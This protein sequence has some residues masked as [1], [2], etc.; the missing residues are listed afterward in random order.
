VST[1]RALRKAN[2]DL[3]VWTIRG[4]F[5][6]GVGQF[7]IQA[8]GFL[9]SVVLA[10]LLSPHDYGLVT[11]TSLLTGLLSC[12]GASALTTV[13]VQWTDLTGEDLDTSFWAGLGMGIATA[14]LLVVGAEY[15]A[16]FFREPLIARLLG[17]QAVGLV[18]APLGIVHSA[19]LLRNMDFRSLAMVDLST[20]GLSGVLAI[21]MALTGWGVWSLVVP[22]VLG[23]ALGT[24]VLWRQM[25][26]RARRRM[27]WGSL[28][29]LA[30]ASLSVQTFNV[31]N[32]VRGN[33]DYLVIGRALG[34]Q[35]LGLYYLA[36]TLATIPQTR[37]VPIATRV[38]FPALSA[39][40]EDPRRVQTG[41]TRAV[42]YI[43]LVTFPLLTGLAILAP[44]FALAVFGARW[45]GAAPLVRILC[46][47]GLLYAVG[48]TTG[49][50]LFSQG[51]AD[52]ACWFGA[53]GAALVTGCVL[54]GA[55]S[56]AMGIAI[57]V[58]VYALISFLP[59]QLL[60]NR[61]IDLG[62]GD[63]L[64]S[65]IPAVLGSV[66]MAVGL[67]LGKLA[68]EATGWASPL[69]ALLVLV[70]LGAA[71]YL[72]TLRLTF[73]GVLATL[74]GVLR[75]AAGAGRAVSEAC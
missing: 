20:V 16:A 25:P 57:A 68:W 45:A 11:A 74:I 5:W 38:L 37:L 17:V 26:W 1:D 43:S 14:F 27:A 48:T 71:L 9:V 36:Y 52:L 75:Q 41:Y 40:Q 62:P 18:L 69:L 55:R 72:G 46:I 58:A 56:G 32:Y 21:G 65:L 54:I 44:E 59:I 15:A 53:G 50:I 70:P 13:L 8:L 28:R 42:Q 35:S 49:S 10:R 33:V 39:V 73:P 47:A 66:S 34:P 22:G 31:L 3:G 12:L 29:V 24:I 4:V 61:L 6:S 2:A 19:L 7:G 23:T 51:R 67:L 63:F 60:T 30:R 64:R